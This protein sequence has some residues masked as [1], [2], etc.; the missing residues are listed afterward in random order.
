M[1]I[2]LQKGPDLG[3]RSRRHPAARRR[4]HRSAAPLHRA[5]RRRTAATRSE[6]DHPPPEMHRRHLREARLHLKQRGEEQATAAGDA[7]ASPGGPCRRRRRGGEEDVGSKGGHAGS[8][9]AATWSSGRRHVVYT[10]I[11]LAKRH[12]LNTHV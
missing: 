7:R 6:P 10:Q 8:R 12:Q 3:G 4:S 11:H 2:Q 1:R 9:A 5:C